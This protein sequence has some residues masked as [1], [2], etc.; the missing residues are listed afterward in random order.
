M[1]NQ[2]MVMVPADRGSSESETTLLT[3]RSPGTAVGGEVTAR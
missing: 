3:T 2:V 1:R